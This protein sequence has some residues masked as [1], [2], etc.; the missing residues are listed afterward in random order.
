MFFPEPKNQGN[1]FNASSY[2]CNNCCG[3]GNGAQ[4]PAGPPGTS[5]PT[6]PS[7]AFSVNANAQTLPANVA[8][9][10]AFNIEEY[11]TNSFF[12]PTSAT[13]GGI[14]AYS[15]KPTIAGYYQVNS[16][17]NINP[18]STAAH[19]TLINLYKNGVEFKRGFQLNALAVGVLGCGVSASVYLNGST[20]YLSISVFST[21]IA[22]I[23]PNGP[24]TYFDGFLTANGQ[25][26]PTGPAGPA[27]PTVPTVAFSVNFANNITSVANINQPGNPLPWSVIEFDTSSR[28]N[29]TAAVVNGIPAYSFKPTTAGY[30]QLEGAVGTTTG[31][32]P[33]TG[34]NISISKNGSM[35]KRGNQMNEQGTSNALQYFGYVV[36]CL[37]YLN[38]TTDYVSLVYCSLNTGV[39]INGSGGVLPLFTY[40]D[41]ILISS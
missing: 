5:A 19:D 36:S 23:S 6:I 1:V 24:Q 33:L 10:V 16:A 26:G 13:V 14:P 4:G 17:V 7:V 27:G 9:I 11:D 12:N 40:F 25:V 39:T 34:F 15:F 21:I 35:Y 18:N 32:N 2:D 8:T 31:L 28:F 41:G 20:D 22:T 38:G 30:Y 3:G 29:N 37:T